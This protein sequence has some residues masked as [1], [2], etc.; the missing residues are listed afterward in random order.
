MLR[1][2]FA[3][4]VGRI[5]VVTSRVVLG[6]PLGQLQLGATHKRVPGLC[7]GQVVRVAASR[8]ADYGTVRKTITVLARN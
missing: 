1:V 6:V 3:E 7:I 5:G 4:A 2:G 8:K